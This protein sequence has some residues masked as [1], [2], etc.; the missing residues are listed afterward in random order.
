MHRVCLENSKTLNFKL[1]RSQRNYSYSK[2][3]VYTNT[4]LNLTYNKSFIQ[5]KKLINVKFFVKIAHLF[6]EEMIETN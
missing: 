4:F 1:N 5:Q 6:F 2:S 3:V